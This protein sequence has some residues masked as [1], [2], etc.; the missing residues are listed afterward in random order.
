[1]RLSVNF[2][3]YIRFLFA[4][5]AP[6]TVASFRFM[7][8]HLRSATF[9]GILPRTALRLHGVIY[10][11]HLWRVLIFSFFLIYYKA[12]FS[13]MLLKLTDTAKDAT[14]SGQPY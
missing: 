7:I 1:V 3:L 8:A 14:P 5:T 4:T 11:S 12:V 13:T 9:I 2:C 10:F 6:L